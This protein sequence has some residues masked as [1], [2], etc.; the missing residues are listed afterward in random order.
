MAIRVLYVHGIGEIGGAETDLLALLKGLDRKRFQPF[1]V[2]PS[3][4]PLITEIE[5]LNIPVYGITIPAWRK[6]K[7]W[8]AIPA[9]IWKLKKLIHSWQ[10][11]LIH[12]NDY[13]WSPLVHAAAKQSHVPVVVHVRQQIESC[14]V[15]QYGLTKPASLFAVSK[16]IANVL[17]ASGVDPQK[18]HVAY[19]GVDLQSSAPSSDRE[20]LRNR[21]GLDSQQPVIGTIANIFPRKGFEYLIDALEAIRQTFPNICCFIV[22]KGDSSYLEK[23]QQRVRQKGLDSNIVFAGFQA[24][25]YDYLNMLDVFVLP[26]VLEGFGIVLIEAMAMGKPVVATSVGGI[27]EVVEDGVT[28]ILVTP[29]DSQQLADAVGRL[30]QDPQLSW[31]M[32]HAGRERAQ[33]CFSREQAISRIQTLYQAVTVQ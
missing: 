28:G 21:Y 8:I 7:D 4:G 29:R 10:V 25:V 33:R 11:N 13:W 30:L 32:G 24:N 9:V 14:R 1:V 18:V 26:S 15:R 3:L 17:L 22:G 23:L 27:P 31:Q 16:N 19:S 12:V 20:S 6:A 5:R 2:C